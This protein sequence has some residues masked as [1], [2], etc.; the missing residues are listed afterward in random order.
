MAIQVDPPVRTPY[1]YGLLS[2][3]Q[4]EEHGQSLRFGTDYVFDT[5]QCGTGMVWDTVCE[6][7]FE[8]TFTA[9]S[10]AEKF[11]VTASPGALGDYTYTIEELGIN[12]QPLEALLT[13]SGTGPLIVVVCEVGGLERCVTITDFNPDAA[14][15]VTFVFVSTQSANPPKV[16]T[17]GIA[18]ASADPFVVIDGALCT[19]I[20]TPDMQQKARDALYTS[21]QRLVEQQFWANLSAEGATI[22]GAGAVSLTAGVALLEQYLRDQS[23]YVGMLHSDAYVAPYASSV[24]AI[25]ETNPETIKRTS[26]WTP[27]VFGGGYDLTGPAG[28]AAP[29][30][31]QAWIYATGQVII[32]R[33]SIDVHEAFTVSNN[34]DLV[35]AER[36][37][38]V[39]HDCPIAAVLVQLEVAP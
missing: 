2:T 9:S 3:A 31:D 38:V 4:V 10:T 39:I 28:E 6:D 26:L 20:A 27:W 18:T 13:I 17:E 24:E 34:Q 22:L 11:D 33:G 7:V 23:G 1:R 25:T 8:V 15:G 21:E 36:S 19:L 30:P 29:G 12:E 32:H 37:Y 16:I 5:T 14:E 35:I